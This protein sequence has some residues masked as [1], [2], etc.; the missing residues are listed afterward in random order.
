MS[1]VL[2]DLYSVIQK[3]LKEMP[4]QSYTASLVR[5][6]KHYVAR[7]VGEEA[8]EV[9]TA[10]LAEG[11]ER[12]ISESADLLYHLLVLLALDGISLDEVYAELR[13]RMR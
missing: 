10:S 9:V 6:G 12:V 13:R 1:E 8:V 7:K 3:R 11:R 2:G 5:K 4:E